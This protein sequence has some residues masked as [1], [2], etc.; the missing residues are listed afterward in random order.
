MATPT[1]L[2]AAQT[3]GNVL[4]AAYV[5]DLRGAFRILQI[6]TGSTTTGLTTTSTSFVDTNLTA[7]ITPQSASSQILVYV[8]QG[9]GTNNSVATLQLLR[10]ATNVC[11]QGHV[12]YAA[13]VLAL[14]YCAFTALDSPATTSATTYKTQ[15]KVNALTG[16]AQ[17]SDANGTQ[18][19]TIILMEVSA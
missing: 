1:N 10:G 7:T 17:F 16:Y 11:T 18:R 3:T 14:G 4:T 2:P 15:M 19:S 9:M 6:V 12:V 5:N 8:S 13:G